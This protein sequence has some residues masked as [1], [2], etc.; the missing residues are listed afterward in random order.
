[1]PD[2]IIFIFY[3][4]LFIFSTIGYGFIFSRFINKELFVLNIGYQGI[5]GFFFIFNINANIFFV[6][7]ISISIH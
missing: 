2:H 3:I 5:I 1:M 4:K 7:I 6:L